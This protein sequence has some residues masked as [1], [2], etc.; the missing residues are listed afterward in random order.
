MEVRYMENC[1]KYVKAVSILS[2]ILS[3][4]DMEIINDALQCYGRHPEDHSYDDELSDICQIVDAFDVYGYN[5]VL[6]EYD[7]LCRSVQPREHS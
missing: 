6:P 3:E 4:N 7:I 1:N 5:H 2:G